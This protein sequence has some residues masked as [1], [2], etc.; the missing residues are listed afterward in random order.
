MMYIFLWISLALNAF[1]APT[2]EELNQRL[3]TLEQ[4]MTEY[5]ATNPLSPTTPAYRM[6]AITVYPEEVV[7]EVHSFLDPVDVYGRVA[8]DVSVIGHDIVVQPGGVVHGDATTLFG[9]IRSNRGRHS[10]WEQ[11][12][13]YAKFCQYRIE[14]QR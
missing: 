4:R 11:T 2:N 12:S 14:Y 9:T 7:P 5:E 6:N 1:S 3:D 10:P 13:N 8:G